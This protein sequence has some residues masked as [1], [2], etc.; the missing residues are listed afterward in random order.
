MNSMLWGEGRVAYIEIQHGPYLVMPPEQAV[1]NGERANNVH[2]ANLVWLDASTNRLIEIPSRVAP[3]DGPRVSY[4]WGDPQGEQASGALVELPAGYTST[5][6]STGSS[7]R[8]VVIKGDIRLHASGAPGHESL[9]PGSFVG[10]SNAGG[11]GI[12]GSTST[13]TVLYVRSDA[14]VEV[15]ATPAM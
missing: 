6:T 14:P 3:A 7:L 13:S 1:D 15:V 10:S 5:L 11:A 4:L 9:G 8:I 12:T 2:A